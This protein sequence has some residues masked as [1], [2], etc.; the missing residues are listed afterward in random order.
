MQLLK[1]LVGEKI[2]GMVKVGCPSVGKFEG[3][4]MVDGK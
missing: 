1:V 4:E 3:R 2:L